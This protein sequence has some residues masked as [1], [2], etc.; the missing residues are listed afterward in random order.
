MLYLE[1]KSQLY[2]LVQVYISSSF[3]VSIRYKGKKAIV[4]AL[5]RQRHT[6]KSSV[7]AVFPILKHIYKFFIVCFM[8]PGHL[9]TKLQPH[10]SIENCQKFPF[11]PV[12]WPSHNTV[13]WQCPIQHWHHLLRLEV[14]LPH[15]DTSHCYQTLARARSKKKSISH[16]RIMKTSATNC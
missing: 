4:F 16:I 15:L 14:L 8:L 2:S 5:A 6:W 10:I 9:W 11:W 12:L 13:H 7:F 1:D 3:L